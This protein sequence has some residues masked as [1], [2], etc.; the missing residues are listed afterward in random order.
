MFDHLAVQWQWNEMEK[1]I[2]ATR[3]KTEEGDRN[4]LRCSL[5][6]IDAIK[7]NAQSP[8]KMRCSTFRFAYEKRGIFLYAAY[9]STFLWNDVI[10]CFSHHFCS[11]VDHA[12]EKTYT[13]SYKHKCCWISTRLTR[14]KTTQRKWFERPQYSAYF[15]HKMKN[16]IEKKYVKCSNAALNCLMTLDRR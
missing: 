7:Q 8:N 2:D 10:V 14:T 4:V 6:R 5:I 15:S 1:M 12:R 16:C 13:L 9:C 3:L 11:D